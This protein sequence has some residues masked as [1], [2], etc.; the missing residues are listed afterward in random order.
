MQPTMVRPLT[1]KSDRWHDR[2]KA[3]VGDMNTSTCYQ[4][5][6]GQQLCHVSSSCE[7]PTA[8]AVR[9]VGDFNGWDLAATPMRRATRSRWVAS[10]ALNPGSYSYLFVVDGKPLLDPNADVTSGNEQVSRITIS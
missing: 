1:S 8:E 7:A 9:L 4:A 5:P 2:C 10:L 6:T 3:S